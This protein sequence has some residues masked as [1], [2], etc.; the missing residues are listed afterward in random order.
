MTKIFETSNPRNN[1]YTGLY[2]I[3]EDFNNPA[4]VNLWISQD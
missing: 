4:S 3:N 1:E 2:H